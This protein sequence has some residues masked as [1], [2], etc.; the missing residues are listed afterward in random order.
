M[1]KLTRLWQ[2][3]VL[4]SAIATT[5]GFSQEHFTNVLWTL[6][7]QG[8]GTFSAM[9]LDPYPDSVVGYTL[10]SLETDP[11]SGLVGLAYH[12]G[13]VAVLA[14]DVLLV[15]PGGDI[16]DLIRFDGTDRVFFF[17]ELE[18]GELN[19]DLA[20]VI[21]IPEAINPVIL[22]EI[23][24]EWNN[25]ALYAPAPG[26]PGFDPSETLLGVQYVFI[27]DVPEPGSLSL[28]L[29]GVGLLGFTAAQRRI[30]S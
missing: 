19:P 12:L 5:T 16:S 26:M 10:G 28:L 13:G 29:C 3:F 9:T 8:L 4:T 27:S 15:E 14:G 11:V 30:R 22:S 18:P 17:S 24:P 20:D 7:E 2:A 21:Q 25:G 23:G 6:N 1:K